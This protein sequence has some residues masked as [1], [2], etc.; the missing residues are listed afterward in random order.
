MKEE[1][2][3]GGPGLTHLFF[4]ACMRYCIGFSV[5]CKRWHVRNSVCYSRSAFSSPKGVMCREGGGLPNMVLRLG[6]KVAIS[7]CFL[8]C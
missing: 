4:F 2:V 3:F 6:C 8:S 1:R 7:S 5:C